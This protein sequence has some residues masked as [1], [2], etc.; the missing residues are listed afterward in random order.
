[1]VVLS[2]WEWRYSSGLLGG[3]AGTPGRGSVFFGKT[4]RVKAAALRQAKEFNAASA[5]LLLLEF[6]C[7]VMSRLGWGAADPRLVR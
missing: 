1:M 7:N 5:V 6:V 4:L 2:K 3:V